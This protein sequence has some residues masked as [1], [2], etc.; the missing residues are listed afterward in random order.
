M[1]HINDSLEMS[2]V[3][4]FPLNTLCNFVIYDTSTFRT[5]CWYNVPEF[6]RPII[7]PIPLF[8]SSSFSHS[9]NTT[10][11]NSAYFH[12]LSQKSMRNG[13]FVLMTNHQANEKYFHDN[14]NNQEGAQFPSPGITKKCHSF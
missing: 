10:W 4:I 7:F 2:L 14:Q 6:G 5:L 8:V 12:F 9:I 3:L 11:C 1:H 13:R